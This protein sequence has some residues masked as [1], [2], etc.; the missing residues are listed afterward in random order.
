MLAG[1]LENLILTFF[2]NYMFNATTHHFSITNETAAILDAILDIAHDTYN[3][4][5]VS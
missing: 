5:Q 2:K 1:A 4:G 3:D